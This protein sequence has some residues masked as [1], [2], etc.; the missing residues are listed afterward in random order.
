MRTCV[1]QQCGATVPLGESFTADDRHLCLG[2]A[3]AAVHANPQAYEGTIA[4]NID[5]T[6]CC[7]CGHD[8]GQTELAALMSLPTCDKCL[9]YFRNRP[10]PPWIKLAAAGLVAVV[11]VSLAWNW[12]FLVANHNLKQLG[13]AMEAQDLDRAAEL[14]VSVADRVPESPDLQHLADYFR[15]IILLRDDRSSEALEKL[16]S[17]HQYLPAEWAVDQM[18]RRAEMG[19][20]FDQ[21]DYDKFLEIALERRQAAPEEP[22]SRAMVASAYACKYAE[23]G[24]EQYRK[25]SLDMLEE[26]TAE[27]HSEEMQDYEMRIRHRL[28]AREVIKREEFQKR[29]PNGWTPLQEEGS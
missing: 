14:A 4:R 27:D 17:C 15:G 2:C 11:C 22:M 13:Q 16:R 10:F 12:R 9:G 3:E 28:H 19:V 7:N 1:C 8:S 29:F 23:T 21:A 26:A 5:P 20:A 6:V 24:D 18:I 25:K